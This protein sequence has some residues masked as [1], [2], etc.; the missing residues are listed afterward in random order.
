MVIPANWKQEIIEAAADLADTI[1]DRTSE[2]IGKAEA[3]RTRLRTTYKKALFEK[4]NGTIDED[5]W[6]ELHQEYQEAIRRVDIRIENI[7]RADIKFLQVAKAWVELP[8]VLNRRW[9]KATIETKLKI[10]SWLGSNYSVEGEKVHYELKEPFSLIGKQALRQTWWT[11]K[12]K[13]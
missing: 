4:L 2:E 5:V 3:E 6:N 13:V 1:E 8:E 12:E 7:T 9:N 10:L 11:M